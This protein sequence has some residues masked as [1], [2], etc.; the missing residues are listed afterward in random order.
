M[1]EQRRKQK[2]C[3]SA[4]QLILPDKH[5]QVIRFV[6]QH[7]GKLFPYEAAVTSQDQ[8]RGLPG[9][10]VGKNL[11]GNAGEVSS[12]PDQETKIPRAAE[13]QSLRATTVPAHCT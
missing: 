2:W 12:I 6:R 3:L 13:Q 10:P 8:S 5:Y 11:P 9:G 1:G 4:L 7:G